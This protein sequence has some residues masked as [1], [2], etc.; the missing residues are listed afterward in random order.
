ME[1]LILKKL[2]IES[3]LLNEVRYNRQCPVWKTEKMGIME[4]EKWKIQSKKFVQ[5]CSE[6]RKFK[7][8][9]IKINRKKVEIWGI[10]K[11]IQN[12]QLPK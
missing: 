8:K 11:F 3:T 2:C 12:S 7:W 9:M 4:D 1:P 10:K 5:S 6:D